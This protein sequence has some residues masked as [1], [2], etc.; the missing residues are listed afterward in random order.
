MFQVPSI[1]FLFTFNILSKCPSSTDYTQAGSS[2]VFTLSK[3][4]DIPREKV[5]FR[6]LIHCKGGRASK[7]VY[8][9]Q[10]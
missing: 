8:V 3:N 9:S 10:I 2:P 6:M 4:I 7:N 1:P 5:T